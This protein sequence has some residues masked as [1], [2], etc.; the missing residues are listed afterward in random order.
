LRT[1]AERDQTPGRTRAKNTGAGIPYVF[2]V[3]WLCWQ[4][5]LVAEAALADP[6]PG[7][8]ETAGTMPW[9]QERAVMAIGHPRQ[10][11]KT[12]PQFLKAGENDI[13]CKQK[14]AKN[15]ESRLD[16]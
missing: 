1:W 13:C 4:I 8:V 12:Q 11:N 7:T 6:A 16:I 10:K 9:R 14:A 3:P 2:S 5:R 15:N